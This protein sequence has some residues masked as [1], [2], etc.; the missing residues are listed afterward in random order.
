MKPYIG[1]VF[2]PRSRLSAKLSCAVCGASGYPGGRWMDTH[3][4]GHTP[5]PRC[6]VMRPLTKAGNSFKGWHRGC[7]KQ[8][9]GD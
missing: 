4:S 2:V 3:R 9:R 8:V 6:G 5:C 1:A 7:R